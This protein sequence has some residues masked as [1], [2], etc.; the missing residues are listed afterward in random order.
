M[1][2]LIIIN[3]KKGNIWIIIYINLSFY[4]LLGMPFLL[5]SSNRTHPS[6]V[7]INHGPWAE[8]LEDWVTNQSDYSRASRVIKIGEKVMTVSTKISTGNKKDISETDLYLL[9]MIYK[10]ISL[11]IYEHEFIWIVNITSKK[12]VTT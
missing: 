8:I 7:T 9:G 2:I 11:K 4:Y 5:D 12:L 10:K 6:T 1:I 3:I